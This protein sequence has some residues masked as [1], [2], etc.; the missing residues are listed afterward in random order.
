MTYFNFNFNNF[1]FIT[2]NLT[3]LIII[4]F[5]HKKVKFQC[6][7]FTFLGI[8][9]SHKTWLYKGWTPEHQESHCN[10]GLAS[11]TLSAGNQSG[12]QLVGQSQDMKFRTTAH[13][14][15]HSP[16][17]YQHKIKLLLA[18]VQLHYFPKHELTPFLILSKSMCIC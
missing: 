18:I 3:D 2:C 7:L 6:C 16:Y 10:E 9:N 17:S 8:S 11:E 5:P 1:N 13:I 14:Q 15:D 12:L 4:I